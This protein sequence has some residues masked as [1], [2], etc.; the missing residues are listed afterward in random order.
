M[1]ND[2]DN[3]VNNT[4]VV[5][6]RKIK[7]LKVRIRRKEKRIQKITEE[8][9]DLVKMRNNNPRNKSINRKISNRIDSL[10]IQK[11]NLKNLKNKLRL[12]KAK[13]V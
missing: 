12:L 5:L 9:K 6:R 11:N 2:T 13:M 10:T 3:T 7:N 4:T 8:I 1:N